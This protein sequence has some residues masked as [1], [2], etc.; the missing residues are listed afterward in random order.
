MITYFKKGYSKSKQN[1]EKYKT[2]SILIES[3]EAFV[4]IA[5]TST[6]VT[7][8]HLAFRL[9]VKPISTRLASG[10]SVSNEVLEEPITSK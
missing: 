10:L 6:S 4:I 8:F 9:I 3:V 7:S 5:T 1:H 2:L